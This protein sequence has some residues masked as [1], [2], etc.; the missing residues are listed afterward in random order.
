MPVPTPAPTPAS[1]LHSHETH[2]R[3]LGLPM[4]ISPATRLREVLPRSAGVAAGLTTATLAL[5]SLDRSNDYMIDL[6]DQADADTA[7]FDDLEFSDPVVFLLFSALALL[8]AAPFVGWLVSALSRRVGRVARVL[9]GLGAIAALVVVAPLSFDPHDGPTLRTTAVLAAA[10]LI[11]TYLGLW[12][13]VRWA[14]GRV[15]REVGTMGQMVAR[16]LPIL[17]LA[18]LFLFFSAEIWQIMVALSW[19]RTFAVVGTMAGL[20]VLLVGITTR[21]DM[22]NELRDARPAHTLRTTERVNILLIP[23][24]AT[25]IQAALFATLV[26]GFFL[27][28]G[29]IAIPEATETRWTLRPTHEPGG[30]LAGIPVSVTLVRV[31]LALA[32][33]S[34][35][36]LAAA[37][38]SDPAHHARFVRPMLD[39]A[40]RGLAAREAYLE[41]RRRS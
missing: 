33:F 38:A 30:L 35:L 11:G 17:T 6:L 16:V 8:A 36:N 7:V 23:V 28:L 22:V 15:R 32:A 10:V 12:P 13:L 1:S 41:A 21:D 4:M 5:S 26:F 3:S 24:L 2:L 27:F 31:S 37:A 14:A 9:L 40:V 18:V 39:E 19:P 25:L 29:W 20:T 34:A